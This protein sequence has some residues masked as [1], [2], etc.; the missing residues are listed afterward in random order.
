MKEKEGR[1]HA[2]RREL[3]KKSLI[4]MGYVVPI[5]IAFSIAQPSEVEARIAPT[6]GSESI[7]PAGGSL[8][9]APSDGPEGLEP[10][11]WQFGK[12]WWKKK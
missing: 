2:S 6:G 1:K 12:K 3:L 7:A 4:K 11:Q 5:V 10:V 9:I 8:V